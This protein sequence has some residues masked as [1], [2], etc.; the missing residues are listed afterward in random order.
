VS[1]LRVCFLLPGVM[2]SGGIASVLRHARHLTA[3]HGMEVTLALTRDDI[4]VW[5]ERRLEGLE[6]VPFADARDRHFD[7]AVASWWPTARRL[8]Q[9]QAERHAYYVQSLEDRFYPGEDERR[10]MARATYTLPV[11]FITGARW[12]RDLLRELRPEADCFYVRWGIDKKVFEPLPSVEPRFEGP[13]RILVEGRYGS[14]LKA[15]PASLEA[16]RRMRRPGQVTYV[17]RD[18]VELEH[19]PDE[20]VGP[21]YAEQM[22]E[23]YA[24][25]DVVLKL[26]RVEGMFEPPL[27][28]FHKGATCVVTPVTGHEEF[29][30]H[31]SNGLVVDWDDPRGTTRALELLDRDRALLHELRVNALETARRWPSWEQVGDEFADALREIR[32]RPAAQAREA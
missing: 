4:P 12:M 24:A 23:R 29:V 18:R 17:T 3:R 7:V 13:L 10:E 21:L 15:I 9:M 26:S 30:V 20:V 1:P 28:G 2:I 6:V 25:S 14:W 31:G 16:V 32:R 8:A 27:E 22:A 19:M 5:D 11:S